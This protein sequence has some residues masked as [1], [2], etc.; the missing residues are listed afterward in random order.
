[1]PA[2]ADPDLALQLA[3][4][5]ADL[6]SA[7]VDRMLAQV[8]RRLAK[9]I[10]RPGWA[11][12][13]LIETVQLRNQAQATVD[14]LAVLGPDAINRALI[15]G[16][17]AGGVDATIE[18]G[19]AFVGT[20]TRAVEAL[21][22]ETI[23]S[24]RS[25]H[26]QILRSVVDGYRSVIAEVAAPNV[27][28]GTESRRQA[29]QRALDRF[30]TQGVT[31]FR[32]RSGRS[33]SIESYAEMATRTAVGRAQV[34]GTLDR[35]QE[36]GRDLVIVS[37]APQECERCGR[38]EGRVL[39]ISGADQR[40]PSVATATAEGLLHANCRHSL[41]AY[42]PGLTRPFTHT[43]DPE[44]DRARQEQRRLERGVRHWKRRELVAIDGHAARVA[45]QRRLAWEGRL[46]RHVQAN[47]LMRLRYREVVHGRGELPKHPPR[48]T[49]AP[50]PRPAPRVRPAPP[51]PSDVGGVVSASTAVASMPGTR[52]PVGVEVR[53]ALTGIERI[54]RLPAGMR[55][56]PVE[57]VSGGTAFGSYSFTPKDPAVIR[58]ATWGD[59]K[60]TT[61]SHELGHYLDH[62]LLGGE[63]GTWG[64]SSDAPGM[65]AWR[66]AI[67]RTEATKALAGLP[68]DRVTRYYLRRD[69]QWA[70]S[71][72]QWVALRSG[73]RGMLDE[74]LAIT[75]VAGTRAHSQWSE[76]D[77]SE[78][79]SAIDAIFE[80]R[81]LLT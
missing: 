72:A 48:P 16:W 60:A 66:K 52:S 7:A 26:G 49:P 47:D 42:I 35:Y 10:D 39:S 62:Q 37:D 27:L 76:A 20:N 5:V 40:Y 30:A 77:F 21:A 46:A 78:V 8:A 64:S 59:H 36:G 22:S 11:E 71:Y 18:L 1:M 44:G 12:R 51:V 14:R 41:T 74:A 15:G 6:Y 56:V 50:T 25:T 2:A 54:H 24:V 61:F 23:T 9:G 17:E 13:K 58:V 73:D 45:H 70:R 34:A 28:T 68:S 67:D 31:G 19:G 4:E 63:P 75:N 80:T 3:K 32:D 29:T 53:R 38:W 33:W 81:G 69:E 43:A 65:A 57:S 55:A 79:A